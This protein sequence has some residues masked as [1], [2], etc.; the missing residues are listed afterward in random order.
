MRFFILE[1]NY[2]TNLA[3]FAMK[4]SLKRAEFFKILVL[5]VLVGRP[6][7]LWLVQPLR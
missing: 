6:K 1:L 7:G 3:D 4:V 2:A 5:Y